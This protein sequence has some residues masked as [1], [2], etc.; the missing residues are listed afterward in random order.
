[1]DPGK[2]ASSIKHEATDELKIAMSSQTIRR[3]AHEFGLHGRVAGEKPYSNKTN[4]IKRLN[5]VKMH[6]DKGI[7]FWKHVLWSDESK[8]NLFVSDGRVKIWRTPK[9]EH[10]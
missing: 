10:G 8:Y 9:E 2:S 1:M 5:D 4:W 3:R 6:Q 7:A